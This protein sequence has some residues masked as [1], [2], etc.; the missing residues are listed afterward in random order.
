MTVTAAWKAAHGEQIPGLRLRRG[1]AVAPRSAAAAAGMVAGQVP[2]AW[3]SFLPAAFRK[4]I[5]STAVQKHDVVRL[6]GLNAFRYA[7]VHPRGFDGVVTVY[8]VPQPGA[9]TIV[10]CYGR[11]PSDAALAK[12]GN[13]AASLHLAAAKTYDLTP[14][15]SYARA[16]NGAI[17]GLQATRSKGLRAIKRA[18]T[19]GDEAGAA[20]TIARGYHNAL[21]RLRRASPTPYVMPAHKRITAAVSQV[22]RAYDALA[23]AARS[24]NQSRYD[25]LR[26]VIRRRES[27]LSQELSRLRALGFRT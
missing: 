7:D 18:K 6:G 12:C 19:A 13:V 17:A 1:L 4:R 16:L 10:A 24:R 20:A 8:A 26:Q 14:P 9:A 11:T 25:V 21:K 23:A 27:A 2:I 15:R 3:P 22:A 5:G